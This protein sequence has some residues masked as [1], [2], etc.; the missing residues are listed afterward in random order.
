MYAVYRQSQTKDTDSF[1]D[2]QSRVVL[3]LDTVLLLLRRVQV[4]LSYYG[5]CGGGGGCV[6]YCGLESF[7]YRCQK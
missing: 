6:K 4:T 7:K 1:H 2:L 5:G 3:L